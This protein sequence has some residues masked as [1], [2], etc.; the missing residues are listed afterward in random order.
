V[1]TSQCRHGAS[2]S[3]RAVSSAGRAGTDREP[4]CCRSGKFCA[5]THHHHRQHT[6]T[7]THAH[8]HTLYNGARPPRSLL[9]ARRPAAAAEQRSFSGPLTHTTWRKPRPAAT[10]WRRRRRRP[11]SAATTGQ[12]SGKG[13]SAAER[14]QWR[15]HD[16]SSI[17]QQQC[18][19][20]VVVAAAASA[21]AWP[22]SLSSSCELN[23]MNDQLSERESHREFT[24]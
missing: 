20:V 11:G 12:S 7:D 16:G 24:H 19:I 10:Q 21:S 1:L 18:A 13:T 5:D 22:S 2:P 6:H 8:T 3:S 9:A 14:R 15:W 17:R 23:E 4:R